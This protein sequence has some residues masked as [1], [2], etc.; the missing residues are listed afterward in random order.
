MPLKMCRR[1]LIV[2]S[3]PPRSSGSS[4]PR[5]TAIALSG[6]TNG[7]FEL[8]VEGS[9]LPEIAQEMLGTADIDGQTEIDVLGEL[10]NV[11][12]GNL[13]AELP[14]TGITE[15]SSPAVP[16]ELCR[17]VPVARAAFSVERR[18]VEARFFLP[19]Q[20]R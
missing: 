20:R 11:I 15:L 6:N 18:A 1:M 19:E 12:C 2:E 3:V 10:A 13:L 14:G 5:T 7:Y 8:D 16:T 17:G 4:G 9:L